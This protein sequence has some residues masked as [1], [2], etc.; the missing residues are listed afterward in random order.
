MNEQT[1]CYTKGEIGKVRVVED[2]LPAPVALVAAE[3]NVKVTLSLTRRSIAFFNREAG[4]RR[5][6]YQR[7][8]RAL[9]DEYTERLGKTEASGGREG[10]GVIAACVTGGGGGIR[11]AVPP[12]ARVSRFAVAAQTSNCRRVLPTGVVPISLAAP[13]RSVA[14]FDNPRE[15]YG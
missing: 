10:Q 15:V 5:V 4:K 2:F 7:M 3:D 11:F 9:V 12:C 14:A 13:R 1:V 8:I 6:L